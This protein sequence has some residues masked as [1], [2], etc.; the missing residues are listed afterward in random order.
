MDEEA[1]QR[2]SRNQELVRR[3]MYRKSRDIVRVFNPLPIPFRFMWD[4]Y[5]H[6]VPSESTKD[7]E[8]YLA[9][10]YFRK[11]SQHMI[12]EM[13]RTFGE[14]LLSKKKKTSQPTY[15]DKYIENR[16]VWDKAPRLDN[17]ELL[18]QIAKAVIVGLVEE[19]GMELPEQT[20]STLRTA[21]Q[22][23]IYEQI[24]GGVEKRIDPTPSVAEIT[25]DAE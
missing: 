8:R 19:Y 21:D 13:Q 11:I 22:R 25:N 18:D 15:L 3:E 1:K 6:T 10:H 9:N 17:R 20:P 16:E 5:W 23:D 24:L 7:M 14:D 4:S 12:G 2:V